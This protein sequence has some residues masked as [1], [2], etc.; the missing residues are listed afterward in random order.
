MRTSIAHHDRPY[1]V[2][3]GLDDYPGFQTARILSQRGV[4]VIGVA[5]YSKMFFCRTKS[6]EKIYYL[7]TESDEFIDG[8]V[9][10]G[11]SLPHKAV[12]YPCL[13]LIVLKI[14]RHR[15]L[16]EPY[17]HIALP[18]EEVVE[19]M[20][21]KLSF[22]DYATRANLP[23]P[24][25]FRLHNRQ[26][27]EQAAGELTFPVIVKPPIKT[28]GWEQN[29][30]EKAFKVENAAE[31]LAL[32]DRCSQWIEIVLAQE[33]IPGGD[34]QHFTCNC[35]FNRAHE[36]L[37]SFTSQKL[38]QFPL[39]TG[40]ACLSIECRN[41]E[42]EQ[43]TVQLFQAQKWFGLA[44][45]EM[46]HDVRNGKYYIIEPNIGRPTGRSAL[47][48]GSGV[49]FVHT[50]YCDLTGLPL[51]SNR[52]Q[53]YRGVKWVSMLEDLRCSVQHWQ[54]GDLTVAQ[55]WRSLR[56]KKT[57]AVWS[58]RDPQP[59]LADVGRRLAYK[60]EVLLKRA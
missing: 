59:F 14:S 4:P 18:T 30:T 47:A 12:L 42:V 25:W 36:P 16:L 17:F 57:H 46:K 13:D 28:P 15:H 21:D 49:E 11:K 3:A 29:T 2:V 8:L 37:V 23:I 55:W 9:A 60:A 22:L 58:W 1:A 27:A 35:Y 40:Q 54:R 26:K 44:Y 48:E 52:Q 31:F 24:K 45:L 56:G 5:K 41:E 34:E 33:Y 51:P 7:D 32:Y 53:Q 19:M 43:A 50:M 10:I 20:T 39:E 38:R 6:C